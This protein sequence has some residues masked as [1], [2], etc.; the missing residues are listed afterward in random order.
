MKKIKCSK[1]TYKEPAYCGMLPKTEI[2][3]DQSKMNMTNLRKK[4]GN[5]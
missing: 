5:I 1:T 4:L 3:V 2:R